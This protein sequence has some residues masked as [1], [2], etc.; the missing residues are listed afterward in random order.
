MGRAGPVTIRGLLL[1]PHA[2]LDDLN[3]VAGHMQDGIRERRNRLANA[4]RFA[5]DSLFDAVVWCPR[6]RKHL[7]Q[8][9]SYVA[10]GI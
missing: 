1:I 2:D 7:V 8:S 3:L 6:R 10:E 9:L 4:C 5:I